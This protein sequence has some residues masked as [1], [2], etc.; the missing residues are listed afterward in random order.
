MSKNQISQVLE[1]QHLSNL[2]CLEKLNLKQNPVT[3]IVD[4]RTCVLELFLDRYSEVSL[5][6]GILMF[7]IFS[8][9]LP[10]VIV[11]RSIWL[12][13]FIYI[14]FIA[15]VPLIT[16]IHS[17]LINMWNEF[18]II[19]TGILINSNNSWSQVALDGETTNSQEMSTVAVRVAMLK[20]KL[21]K[22]KTL[23]MVCNYWLLVLLILIC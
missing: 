3:V 9:S 21:K 20:S 7:A 14:F 23:K 5:C 17:P 16:E 8:A 1:V 13:P 6:L 4:Y 11:W 10:L 18:Y 12:S 19:Y 2:P 22:E 15:Y